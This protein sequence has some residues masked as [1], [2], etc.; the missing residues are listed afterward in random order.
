LG[1]AKSAEHSQHDQMSNILHMGV[2]GEDHCQ[3]PW[4]MIHD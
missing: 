3:P 1:R 2:G 4:S